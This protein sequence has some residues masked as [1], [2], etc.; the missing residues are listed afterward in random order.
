MVREL[1]EIAEELSVRGWDFT[2]TPPPPLSLHFWK[3]DEVIVIHVN[4]P[5]LVESNI[6]R[7]GI[8]ERMPVRI[9]NVH[10]AVVLEVVPD[11]LRLLQLCECES[12]KKCT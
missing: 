10:P 5:R 1:I 3:Q 6:F 4:I 9:P 12:R 8:I 2:I 7:G 11:G